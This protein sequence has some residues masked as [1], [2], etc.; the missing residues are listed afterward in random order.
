VILR[1]CEFKFICV[2]FAYKFIRIN[3]P[4]DIFN[5]GIVLGE[6]ELVNTSENVE[7]LFKGSVQDEW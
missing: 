1:D 5:P 6:T 4:V 3:A 2:D 7:Y